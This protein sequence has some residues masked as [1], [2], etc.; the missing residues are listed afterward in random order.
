MDPPPTHTVVVALLLLLAL[1]PSF[2]SAK[3]EMSVNK[4]VPMIGQPAPAFK[5][6]PVG[7]KGPLLLVS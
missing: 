5:G 4:P 3:E 7:G 6:K 2:V 1:A